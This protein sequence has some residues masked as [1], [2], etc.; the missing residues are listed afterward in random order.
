MS[1]GHQESQDES[2]LTSGEGARGRFPLK[3]LVF[4]LSVGFLAFS[5]FHWGVGYVK[6]HWHLEKQAHDLTVLVGAAAP[7]FKPIPETLNALASPSPVA[8]I[9]APTSLKL[10]VPAS[11]TPEKALVE[12]PRIQ[13]LKNEL[14]A[15][16]LLAHTQQ[17]DALEE[18]RAFEAK[19]YVMTEKLRRLQNQQQAATVLA[20]KVARVHA[21][22][23]AP[24]TIAANKQGASAL[25]PLPPARLKVA[26]ANT[27]SKNAAPPYK[28]ISIDR[29]G[30]E[31]QII[32]R[33]QGQLHTLDTNSE[34]LGWRLEHLNESGD[35]V[36]IVNR[37]GKKALLTLTHEGEKG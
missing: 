30:G 1:V 15:S 28:L 17:A 5:Y 4:S 29:W 24:K 21:V 34:V 18:R 23:P 14:A 7:V 16:V 3:M 2:A 32:V 19:L 10:Q 33:H 9:S 11:L 13:Q 8:T 26:T 20:A 37:Q 36:T 35:G 6:D 22:L 31:S 25:K 27:L 12:D